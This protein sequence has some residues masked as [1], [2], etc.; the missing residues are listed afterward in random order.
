[1]IRLGLERVRIANSSSSFSRHQDQTEQVLPFAPMCRTVSAIR[2]TT[3][4]RRVVTGAHVPAAHKIRAVCRP[5]VDRVGAPTPTGREAGFRRDGTSWSPL[6]L[7]K[8]WRTVLAATHTAYVNTLLNRT[9]FDSRVGS[10]FCKRQLAD[11]AFV[12]RQRC[13]YHRGVLRPLLI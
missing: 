4:D 8:M 3:M 11:P 13:D 1:V 12:M 6:T 9:V 5:G 7:N 10:S 2:V